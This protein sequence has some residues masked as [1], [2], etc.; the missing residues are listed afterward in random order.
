MRQHS[1]C[2]HSV[3]PGQGIF[4]ASPNASQRI[5]NNSGGIL[6]HD[7]CGETHE[8]GISPTGGSPTSHTDEDLLRVRRSTC[9]PPCPPLQWP[10]YLETPFFR[11]FE[12]TLSL[13]QL[14]GVELF[15]R[16]SEIAEL[17]GGHP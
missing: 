11:K 6:L 8:S 1:C 12:D 10:S 9:T 2:S 3:L 13:R 5:E 14:E 7:D 16:C 4:V 17:V 15:R